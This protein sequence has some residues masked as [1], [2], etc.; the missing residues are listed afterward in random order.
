MTKSKIAHL[1]NFDIL[2]LFAAFSVVVFHCVN[3]IDNITHDGIAWRGL[4]F[5]VP[6][7]LGMSGY[8]VLQSFANSRSTFHFFWKRAVRIVPAFLAS[9][10]LVWILFGFSSSLAALHTWYSLGIEKNVSKNGALWSL[11]WEELYYG[12]LAALFLMGAYKKPLYIWTLFIVALSISVWSTFIFNNS[13]D[14]RFSMIAPGF[15]IGNLFYL[16]R[17]RVKTAPIIPTA[18]LVAAVLL[19]FARGSNFTVQLVHQSVL[20]AA[21]LWFCISGY[22]LTRRKIPD[23]SYG[24]YV[25]HVPIM[26]FLIA[27]GVLGRGYLLFAVFGVTGLVACASWYLIERPAKRLNN[28]PPKLWKKAHESPSP[29]PTTG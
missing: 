25:Y 26:L 16:Y 14:L 7:F 10:L 3:N 13:A 2:R 19:F 15:F 12:L 28:R 20:I 1:P 17:D 18:A 24:L 8:L 21:I 22:T 6:A 4:F 27:C 11:G 9:L 29:E 23:L 5:A